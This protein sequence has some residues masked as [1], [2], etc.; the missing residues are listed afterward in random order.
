[1]RALVERRVVDAS[2][3]VG[4]HINPKQIE[5]T[6]RGEEEEEEEGDRMTPNT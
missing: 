6:C 3:W 1:M 4:L 2:P 5:E